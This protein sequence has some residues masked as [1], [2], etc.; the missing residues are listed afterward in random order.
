M[1]KINVTSGDIT[2]TVEIVDA[3]ATLV[4]SGGIWFSGVDRAIQRRC[5][6]Y[7][8]AHL[9]DQMNF[10]SDGKV[11]I[12]NGKS[13]RNYNFKD[14]IFVIDDLTLPLKTLVFNT[15]EAAQ[16]AGYK[17]IAMP[18]MRT[19]IMLGIV[20]ETT[21]DTILAIKQGFFTFKE[22]YPNSALIVDVIVYDNTDLERLLKNN[23]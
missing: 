9:A 16:K 10:V 12:V 1:L 3:I 14:V 6:N 19:G 23:L 15:L 8:H 5:G 11:F 20:E 21:L 13:S 18:S 22:K 17:R 2:R 7:Y 4:N